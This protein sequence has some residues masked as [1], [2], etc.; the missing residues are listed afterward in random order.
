MRWRS[1]VYK[2]AVL[3][4]KVFFFFLLPPASSVKSRVLINPF[5]PQSSRCICVVRKARAREPLLVGYRCYLH[6]NLL[7]FII[8]I[9]IPLS[10]LDDGV[11]DSSSSSS[12]E[13]RGL[14]VTKSN[15]VLFVH[16]MYDLG[17]TNERN[18][19]AISLASLRGAIRAAKPHS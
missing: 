11:G 14:F 5:T 1:H 2:H 3:T 9:F 10:V 12:R 8:F 6:Q 16:V 19:T 4:L 18:D 13:S 17:F 7:T 15:T